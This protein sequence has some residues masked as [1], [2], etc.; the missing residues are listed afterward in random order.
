MDTSDKIL[1]G[2]P[3]YKVGLTIQHND[4]KEYSQ[5]VDEW[6]SENDWCDWE[7]E[8]AK[9]EAIKKDSVWTIRWYPNTPVGFFAVA[10]P[11]LYDALRLANQESEK[12]D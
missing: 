3:E 5:K 8:D 12:P 1:L 11:T 6:V 9:A 7:N 2:L 10:A 4:H